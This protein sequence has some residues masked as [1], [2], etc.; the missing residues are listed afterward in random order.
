MSRQLRT[1]WLMGVTLAV[2]G[3]GLG[4]FSSTGS[5]NTQSC[6]DSQYFQVQ[7]GIDHGQ[8]TVPV[9]CDQAASAGY[10][11]QLD[12]A[13]GDALVASLHLSCTMG[14]SCITGDPCYFYAET[15]LVPAGT[16]VLSGTL[17]AGGTVVDSVPLQPP[18]VVPQCNVA[19]AAFLFT[20][21]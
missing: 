20:L 19:Q 11:V 16:T 18:V 8:G 10:F 9:T 4:C 13:A 21:Q 15:G 1:L 12:T 14:Q 17:V 3:V 7:W 5:R 2:G 6:Q